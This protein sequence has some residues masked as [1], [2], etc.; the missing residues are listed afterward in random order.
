MLSFKKFY[1]GKN[2]DDILGNKKFYFGRDV[3]DVLGKNIKEEI[4][5]EDKERE[6]LSKSEY[7]EIPEEGKENLIKIHKSQN[8]PSNI[9]AHSLNIYTG[10][11]HVP[12]NRYLYG[13]KDKESLS[14]FSEREILG[15][16]KTIKNYLSKNKAPETMTL[17]SGS[18]HLPPHINVGDNISMP[19]FSST[20]FNPKTAVDFSSSKSYD[21]YHNHKHFYNVITNK[22]SNDKNDFHVIPYSH[23]INIH[24]SKGTRGLASLEYPERAPFNRHEVLT[25]YPGEGEVLLHPFH[26]IVTHQDIDHKNRLV[27]TH[28]LHTGNLVQD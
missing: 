24:V 11:G 9:E 18:R 3:D 27:I 15:H 6:R 2:A 14:G 26:G 13:K 21:G 12:I 16:I 7:N 1:I 20:T 22:P 28:I 10:A 17:M 4:E 8:K 5:D 23:V 25:S 19:A